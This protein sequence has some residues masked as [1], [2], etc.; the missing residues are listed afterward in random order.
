MASSEMSDENIGVRQR[1]GHSHEAPEE[2]NCTAN[3]K[4]K[5]KPDG[6]GIVKL[7]TGTYW[8]TRIVFLRAL[9]FVYCT[10]LRVML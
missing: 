6:T 2:D 1:M 3:M 5:P 4:E 8:L 10:S 7:D 9:A